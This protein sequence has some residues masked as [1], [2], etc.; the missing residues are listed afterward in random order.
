MSHE[1]DHEQLF[2]QLY[3]NT[4]ISNFCERIKPFAKYMIVI[5]TLVVY[6]L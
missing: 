4:N 1:N 5:V 3:L 6:H 2:F